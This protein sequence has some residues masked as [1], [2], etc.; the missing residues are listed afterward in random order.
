MCF[1]VYGARCCGGS[2]VFVVC[3]GVLPPSGACTHALLTGRNATREEA[4]CSCGS[5][6]WSAASACPTTPPTVSRP[7]HC[8]PLR[9]LTQQLHGA[10]VLH[11]AGLK[12]KKWRLQPGSSATVVRSSFVCGAYLGLVRWVRRAVLCRVYAPQCVWAM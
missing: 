5:C 2:F 8:M 3:P 6:T 12:P 9:A 1:C 4:R 7:A 11:D 10:C